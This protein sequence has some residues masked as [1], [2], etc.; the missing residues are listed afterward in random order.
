M[1]RSPLTSRA[2]ESGRGLRG[3]NSRRRAGSD[4][5]RKLAQLVDPLGVDHRRFAVNTENGDVGA[6]NRTAHVQAAG[7]RDS[8]GCGHGHGAEVLI[9][10][11]HDGLDHAGG[12]DGRGMAV[13]PTLGMDDVG[14]TGAGAA[15]GE[16]VGAI[17]EL[18]ALEVVNQR[19]HF[20]FVGHQEFNVVP[21]GESQV[22]V[23]VFVR[24]LADLTDG[25][26]YS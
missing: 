23:A 22:T 20:G 19:F 3:L 1:Q 13:C 18:S 25:A 11:V 26:R 14:D 10:T 7:Q 6:M 5:E 9:E 21:G 12:V 17:V 15:D 2:L 4:R 24:D 8:H 16:L